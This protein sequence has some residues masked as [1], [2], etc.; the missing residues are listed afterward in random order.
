MLI[1]YRALCEPMKFYDSILIPSIH[2][3]GNYSDFVKSSHDVGLPFILRTL[4]NARN[5]EKLIPVQKEDLTVDP[6]I[7]CH[8]KQPEYIDILIF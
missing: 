8:E 4:C 3:I 2:D 5:T 1:L 6:F 7:C